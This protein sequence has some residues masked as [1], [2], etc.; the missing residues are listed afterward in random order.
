M[1]V[2]AAAAY[3]GAGLSFIVS[4]SGVRQQ[5]R[6]A[7]REAW[8]RQLEIALGEL[9]Q[10]A[11]SERYAAGATILRRLA[12]SEL[13][14]PEDRELAD[15]LLQSVQSRQARRT[16][17]RPHLDESDTSTDNENSDNTGGTP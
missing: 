15:L 13:A 11:D 12:T 7:Q 2:T 1:W 4:R 5:E 3:V 6:T 8:L 17:S 14:R 16:G 9:A 10:G